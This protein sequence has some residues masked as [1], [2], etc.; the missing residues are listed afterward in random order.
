M[1]EHYKPLLGELSGRTPIVLSGL[2][3]GVEAVT[4]P[5]RRNGESRVPRDRRGRVNVTRVDLV[6]SGRTALFAPPAGLSR[7][8]LVWA[9]SAG[10]RQWSSV[11]NRFGDRAS[12]AWADQADDELAELRPQR[13]PDE[14]RAGLLELLDG[15]Q[16][17]PTL[18]AE[19]LVLRVVSAGSALVP[20]PGTT[21]TAK[22]SSAPTCSSTT[23]DR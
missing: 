13:D 16:T 15:L 11:Q 10:R 5:V 6:P 22:R 18:V 4:V 20:P 14:V 8:D 1:R 9:L 2:P 3:Q 17:P 12:S 23:W 19:R 21:T 7:T